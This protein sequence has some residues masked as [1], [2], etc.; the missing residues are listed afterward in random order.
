MSLLL[1]WTAA[2]FVV[3]GWLW[4]STAVEAINRRRSR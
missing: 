3:S 2:S 1:A 4:T